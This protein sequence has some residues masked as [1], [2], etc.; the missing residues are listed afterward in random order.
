MADL[1]EQG[2]DGRAERAL[3]AY[4]RQELSAPAT[5]IM[6]YAEMLMDD[7]APADRGQQ[8]DDLQRILDASRTLHR[9]I[10]SLLDPATIHRTDGSADLAELRRTLRHDLRTPINAIKGYGEMLRE[11]AADGS[12]KTFVADLDKLLKEATQF[13]DRID[14][15]VT[16]SGGDAAP[17]Q[18]AARTATGTG[19][20]ASMVESLIEAVRPVAANE[21]DLAAVRPSRILVVD[22]NESNRDLLSRRLQRQGHSV[23]Q[24]EDGARALALVE[25]EALD[26]VL[27]DLM[28]PGISGYDVLA[29]L[30]RDPRHR[31]IPVIMIS[32]LS[33]LDS[34]VRCIEAGAD[35]YLA[36][37]FDPTLLRARVGA[38][39]ERKRLHDQVVAQAADLAAQAA[40]LASWNKTLEQR[41]A[42]QLGEI[43]RAGRMKRFL[44]PQIADLV[45]S[46]GDDR[47]LE[48][49]RRAITVVFCDLR[50][51]TAF[52]ETTEPEEV[53]SVLREY[54]RVLGSLIH[55]YGGTVERFTGDGIMM[56]FNDPVPCTDP[57]LRAAQMAIEM[58]DQVGEFATKWRKQG[59]ELGFGLGIAHGYATLGPIGFEGR[60]DYGAV[61]TVVNLAAR[62]CA[63]ARAGQI[64]VDPKVHSAIEA[65]GDFEPAGE[66]VLKGIQRPVSSFNVLA[67]RERQ[68]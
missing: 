4:V 19:A 22:D 56:F 9:L 65:F 44:S 10:L 15:L 23:L 51:F 18:G 61:G 25:T 47:M 41:V 54:H 66:L 48:S 36:K 8:T 50:G 37:P 42:D 6:G 57:S 12:T 63:E 45:L 67:M 1:T 59:H 35:D 27:L 38:S 21:A 46:S 62:L 64:L 11:D 58:R 32:A 43:E 68:A 17:S 24:A 34:I 55:K 13:L 7:A 29:R 5:A 26:L 28:M 20:P 2:P 40:D 60:I 52:S 16:F 3:V 30:K 14:D 53:M 49:H 39:L 31:D 33:E